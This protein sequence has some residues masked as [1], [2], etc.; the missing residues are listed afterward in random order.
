MG[1]KGWLFV[2]LAMFLLAGCSVEAGSNIRSEMKPNEAA[3][4][5]VKEE[6]PKYSPNLSLEAIQNDGAYYFAVLKKEDIMIY[7]FTYK[8]S[9]DVSI[10]VYLKREKNGWKQVSELPFIDYSTTI[11]KEAA[12]YLTEEMHNPRTKGIVVLHNSL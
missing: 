8:D 2:V 4:A 6:I 5:I 9:A 7:Q 10:P 12:R 3:L 1:R 11:G